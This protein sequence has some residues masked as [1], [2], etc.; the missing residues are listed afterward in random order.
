MNSIE[1]YL[2][3]LSRYKKSDAII[4]YLKDNKINFDVTDENGNTLLIWAVVNKAPNLV[5]ILLDKG[6]NPNIQNA[7]KMTAL[8]YAVTMG[9]VQIAKLLVE[10]G[11]DKEI[12]N[13]DEQ[14]PIQCAH[15]SM[16]GDFVKVFVE[17][18]IAESE[19]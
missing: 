5:E 18:D 12:K 3:E 16:V 8:H 2:F 7:Q 6:A 14:T 11:A 10:N 13:I 9:R 4:N 19:K 1:N 17:A 15:K